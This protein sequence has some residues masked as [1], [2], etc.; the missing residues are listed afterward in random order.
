MTLRFFSPERGPLFGPNLVEQ[1]VKPFFILE[2]GFW[3]LF[4]YFRK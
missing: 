3:F 2:E 1:M 4:S